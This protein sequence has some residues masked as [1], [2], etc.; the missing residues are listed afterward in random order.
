MY[1][2]IDD[3]RWLDE[4]IIFVEPSETTSGNWQIRYT[5]SKFLIA[6]GPL[7]TVGVGRDFWSKLGGTNE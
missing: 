6:E 1:P 5:K 7:N 2:K 3:R 4:E